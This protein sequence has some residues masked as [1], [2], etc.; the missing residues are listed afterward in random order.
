MRRARRG[1]RP[2]SGFTLVELALTLSIVAILAALGTV[3]F[4]GY[5]ERARLAQVIVDLRSI[6]TVLRDFLVA[7]SRLPDS[8]TEA[9][10][11]G[12]RDVWGNPYQY[13]R[14]DTAPLG[15]ARKDRFLVPI[16]SDFDLYSMG[17]DGQ[18]R[19]ALTAAQSR[20]DIIRASDGSYYGLA[21]NY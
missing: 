8:L 6:D 10:L 3:A 16:N 7:Q 12:M 5:L 15:K 13:L 14:L 9:G 2:G 17:A 20:D 11:D 19:P 1:A 18:S 4:R 21:A